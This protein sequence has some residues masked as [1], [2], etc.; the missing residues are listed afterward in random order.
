MATVT[1][2][3]SGFGDILRRELDGQNVSIRELARRLTLGEPDRL[4]NVRRSLG[5]Y[6]S[7]EVAPGTDAREAISDALGVEYEM[8]AE[9]AIRNARRE[10]VL[11]ALAPLAD[12]LLDLA[13]EVSA[14]RERQAV[15]R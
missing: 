6:I 13:V 5:R 7:G 15:E 10:K 12:V 2:R 8:F 9:D 11:D 14:N 1:R 3:R 4:E